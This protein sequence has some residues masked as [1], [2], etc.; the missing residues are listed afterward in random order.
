MSIRV[1]CTCSRQ[2]LSVQLLIG[3]GHT[4]EKRR[5]VPKKK[6]ENQSQQQVPRLS[7]PSNRVSFP[8]LSLLQLRH[9]TLNR[10]L[11]DSVRLIHGIKYVWQARMVSVYQAVFG[12]VEWQIVDVWHVKR[13]LRHVR[14]CS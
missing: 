2:P 7:L 14:D 13:D 9:R 12:E 11:D 5:F 8:K 4:L 1:G 3:V 10:S 6:N